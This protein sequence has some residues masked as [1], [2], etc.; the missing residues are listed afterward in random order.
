MAKL[1]AL[2]YHVEHKSITVQ[3]TKKLELPS[4]GFA[5]PLHAAQEANE[6]KP[7]KLVDN[8]VLENIIP[9]E[10]ELKPVTMDDDEVPE[11][12]PEQDDI[13]FYSPGTPVDDVKVEQPEKKE[14][15]RLP[16]PGSP[17]TIQGTIQWKQG[18]EGEVWSP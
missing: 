8:V 17:V 18:P 5:F 9:L 10:K 13:D 4:D 12:P 7:N 16:S 1:E 11:R 15:E 2:D 14:A 6:P 3:R